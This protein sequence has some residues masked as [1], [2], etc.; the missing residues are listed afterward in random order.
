MKTFGFKVVLFIGCVGVIM[1]FVF[2]ALSFLSWDSDTVASANILSGIGFIM[3]GISA[4]EL[5]VVGITKVIKESTRGVMYYISTFAAPF[6]FAFMLFL[7][8]SVV[9]GLEYVEDI[10]GG[11]L[12]DMLYSIGGMV[13]QFWFW[14]I[15]LIL[16][17]IMLAV[18]IFTKNPEKMTEPAS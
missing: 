5:L 11:I 1:F 2:L 13:G 17:A 9:F 15:F 16:E 6:I 14:V 12:E 18:N 8:L 3:I 7:T 10:Q 4:M